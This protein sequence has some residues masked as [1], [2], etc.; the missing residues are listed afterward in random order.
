VAHLQPWEAKTKVEKKSRRRPSRSLNRNPAIGVKHSRQ[1]R[2][3]RT[4]SRPP[5]RSTA[6][7]PRK[8]LL[9][10]EGFLRHRPNLGKSA[11]AITLEQ[12]CR[13]HITANSPSNALA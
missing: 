12:P 11:A 2:R 5:H 8:G 3:S 6:F 10:P 13:V 1:P 4:G 7:D 9:C